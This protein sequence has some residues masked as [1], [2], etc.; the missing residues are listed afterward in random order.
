[1]A[2]ETFVTFEA[3]SC[4]TLLMEANVCVQVAPFGCDCF[5]SETFVEDFPRLLRK[6]FFS[7]LAFVT[8]TEPAFCDAANQ[9][10]CDHY[11]TTQSCCCE[12]QTEA[13]RKCFFN[14]VLV[15]EVPMTTSCEDTCGMPATVKEDDKDGG[16]I[17]FLLGFLVAIVI[18]SGIGYLLFRKWRAP[19]K[20]YTLPTIISA[21]SSDDDHPKTASE[22]GDSVDVEAEGSYPSGVD[23]TYL[24]SEEPEGIFDHRSK[25]GSKTHDESKAQKRHSVSSQDIMSLPGK[26]QSSIQSPGLTRR[27]SEGHLGATYRE[28]W[29][30]S[31]LNVEWE[32]SKESV[33]DLNK[34]KESVGSMLAQL[35]Q[36]RL[37]QEE[38]MISYKLRNYEGQLRA[39]EDK[40]Q[41]LRRESLDTAK[42]IAQLELENALLS[43]KLKISSYEEA[44][45]EYP[46]R[47]RGRPS[48]SSKVEKE[49][50]TS[51]P[52]GKKSKRKKSKRKSSNNDDSLKSFET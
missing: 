19:Q 4:S 1:M 44:N 16:G 2:D 21:S 20:E 28:P 29:G 30:G 37:D 10:V 9:M 24:S 17:V 33:G 27:V 50:S 14:T 45:E 18:A 48:S 31:H 47:E 3:G 51:Y 46:R 15:D 25:Q 36:A 34:E 40:A 12:R 22:D 32:S 52:K 6:N 5:N 38:R 11:Q 23:V 43:A 39:A 35:S 41:F 13:Y 26:S 49:D 8:V 42:R 7:A